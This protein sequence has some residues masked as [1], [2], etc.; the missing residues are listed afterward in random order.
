MALDDDNDDFDDDDDDA[1]R[2]RAERVMGMKVGES[3]GFVL[4]FR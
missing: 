3:S 2:P 1:K 4:F